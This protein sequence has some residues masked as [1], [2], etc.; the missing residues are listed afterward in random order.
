[1]STQLITLLAIH[2]YLAFAVSLFYYRAL[3]DLVRRYPVSTT[4]IKINLILASLASFLTWITGSY[5]LKDYFQGALG[6]VTS[7]NVTSL[8]PFFSLAQQMLFY[9]VGLVG[10]LTIVA[11]FKYG[12]GF[13]NTEHT[14]AWK[15][16]F[17]MCALGSFFGAVLIFFGI[18]VP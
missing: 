9:G 6:F 10:L 14:E 11:I 18:M 13:N 16:V 12:N 4:K 8:I 3:L 1:M 17:T 5:L 2:V 15:I 7:E